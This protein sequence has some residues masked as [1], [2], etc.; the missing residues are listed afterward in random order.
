VFKYYSL[1][2]K[3]ILSIV[4]FSAE[5]PEEIRQISNLKF[6]VKAIE[7]KSQNETDLTLENSLFESDQE[8][9][10]MIDDTETKTYWISIEFEQIDFDLLQSH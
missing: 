8:I 2:N 9:A 10:F 5:L 4:K 3:P 1:A 7:I 6:H